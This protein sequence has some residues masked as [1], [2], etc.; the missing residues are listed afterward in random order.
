MCE[1]CELK[2]GFKITLCNT[3]NV[4]MLVSY[5]H[6]PEFSIEEKCKIEKMF[7]NIRWEQRK[8]HDHAH[9]HIGG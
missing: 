4:L 7:S 8:I 5:D 1:L 3:C 9:C 6:K 2:G